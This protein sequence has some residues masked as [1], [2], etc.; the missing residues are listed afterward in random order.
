M[1]TFSQIGFV[2]ND[3]T[4]VEIDPAF[5]QKGEFETQ[6]SDIQAKLYSQIK[7]SK[8]G[9]IFDIKAR[10]RPEIYELAEKINREDNIAKLAHQGLESKYFKKIIDYLVIDKT[11]P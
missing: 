3:F 5:E 10:I 8:C 7:K 6:E 2:S 9:I 11:K 1:P 4:D